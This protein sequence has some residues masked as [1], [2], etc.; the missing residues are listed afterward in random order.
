[1]ST[2]ECIDD[3]GSSE[4]DDSLEVYCVN[5]IARFCLSHEACPWRDGGTT[6]DEVT[7]STSGLSGSYMANMIGGCVGGEGSDIYCC[8]AEGRIGLAKN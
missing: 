6:S 2:N 3:G 5:D 1:M 7:C 8:S 4:G